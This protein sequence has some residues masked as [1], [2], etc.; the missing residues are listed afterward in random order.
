M[1]PRPNPSHD[2]PDAR[3]SLDPHAPSSSRWPKLAH[4]ANERLFALDRL[5]RSR[6]LNPDAQSTANALSETLK[7][8]FAALLEFGPGAIDLSGLPADQAHPLHLAV[9]LRA[10]LQA[11]AL[12]PGWDDAL[13]VA[14]LACSRMGIDE[15]RALTG[16]LKP[17][18]APNSPA[19]GSPRPL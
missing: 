4:D 11:K 17:A 6:V 3:S 9:T 16:L 10:T 14:R 18:K 15:Q 13:D 8:V 12:T 19:S 5:W 2:R 1:T 7:P